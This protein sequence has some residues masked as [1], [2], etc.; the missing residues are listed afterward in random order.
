[1]KAA[2]KITRAGYTRKKPG[3]PWKNS[4]FAEEEMPDKILILDQDLI[5]E[6]I[7]DQLYRHDGQQLALVEATSF[8]GGKWLVSNVVPFA[9][10][11]KA[12]RSG[13]R[14]EIQRTDE[15]QGNWTV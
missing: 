6:L 8:Q 15:T 3:L 9:F 1:M 12:L 10:R 11:R 14:T 4:F 2:N 7:R 5:R 13:P